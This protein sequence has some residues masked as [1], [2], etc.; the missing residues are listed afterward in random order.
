MLESI[1]NEYPDHLFIKLDGLDDAIIGST[2]INTPRLVYS[3]DKIIEILEERDGA[4]YHEATEFFWFNIEPLALM[5]NG[6]VF[7]YPDNEE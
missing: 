5:V 4:D 7:E 2:V 3:F 6:P 1:F